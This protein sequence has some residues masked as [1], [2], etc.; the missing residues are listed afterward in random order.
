MVKLQQLVIA[1]VSLSF[2]GCVVKSKLPAIAPDVISENV[3]YD[4]DDPSIWVNQADASQSII[5]GT[6]KD[7]DGAI[8]AFDLQGKILKD[9]CITGIQRPNNVDL[10]YDFP[11]TDSTRT[12]II[13]FTERERKMLRIYSVPDMQPLDG[14][15]FPVFADAASEEEQFPM[16]I[17]LYHSQNDGSFY[18]IV[19]RKSGPKTDYLYQYKIKP[20]DAGSVGVDLVRKFGKFSGRK[21]IEA[22]AVDDALGYVYYSD[23]M[24]CVRKYQAE[25]NAGKEELAC[26]GAGDF[27]EDIEG[28]AIAAY[29]DGS[30]YILVSDQQRGQFNIYDR[31]TNEMLKAVNLSTTE[32]DGCDAVTVTL[33]ETFSNGLFVAMNDE[34]NFYFYDLGKILEGL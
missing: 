5:F 7:T 19:G 33:N 1:L 13:A 20:K 3:K 30:G 28:I 27:Q 25:P 26:F 31:K 14:G 17:A 32:T 34:G 22:I 23:E 10:R 12:A 6:D 16:G 8:F 24:E 18:A 11:L 15:G 21:E 29:S 9:K 4:T 2:S